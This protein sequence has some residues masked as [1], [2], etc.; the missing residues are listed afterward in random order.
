M[1]L[2]PEVY[3]ISS[4]VQ[5]Q[6][7]QNALAAGVTADMFHTCAEEYEWLNRY[8]AQHRKEPSV[9][10]F[11]RAHPRFRIIKNCDDTLHFVEEVRKSHARQRMTELLRDQA[12]L[13]AE[14]RVDEA[15][16]IGMRA[17]VQIASEMGAHTD[18]DP[19]E[20]W[21]PTYQHVMA[22]KANFDEFGMAG[23]PTGFD[24]LDER[25]GGIGR[26]QFAI[27][28]ARLGEGK[29]TKLLE[30]AAA[31]IL[32]P[33]GYK[34]HY[35]SLEMSKHEVTMRLH[36]LLS[37]RLG[38]Q[39]FKS[40]ELAQGRIADVKAYRK[41]LE[42]LPKKIQGKITIS[43]VRGIGETEIAAQIERHQPDLYIL[44]YLTLAKMRGDGGWQDIG[45]FS[46]ACKDMSKR[47][48][49]GF[50]AAAQ[51][52]R[53][54]ADKDATA[55]TTIG[56]S[57]QIGQDADMVVMIRKMSTRI[58]EMRLDKYRHGPAGYKWYS[59]LDLATGDAKEVSREKALD[60]IDI[61]KQRLDDE[62]NAEP[63]TRIKKLQLIKSVQ[64]EGLEESE[65]PRGAK[66]TL[67]RKK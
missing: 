19:L 62:M 37:G 26:G 7:F 12:D 64:Q 43:D 60:I 21:S 15:A 6:D 44:D 25:T 31:A 13:I 59:F 46:K 5:N 40:T 14:G 52:N 29:S 32:A 36:N 38:F 35:A 42:E 54:G 23:I 41:F 61:D 47:Y 10:A 55:A 1:A 51:L 48:D 17:T 34:V 45:R 39:V 57:D 58:T 20:D 56:G 9:V 50:V 33:A 11:R 53:Q 22:R 63:P 8:Y 27:F 66:R 3:L 28:A 18:I 2:S 49:L 24:T 65:T 30:I 16:E 67:R 4:I